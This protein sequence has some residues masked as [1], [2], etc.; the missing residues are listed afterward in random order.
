MLTS[1]DFAARPIGRFVDPDALLAALAA[2]VSVED[3]HRRAYAGEFPP[4][5]PMDPRVLM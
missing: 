5:K 2:G 1:P 4:S 3:V